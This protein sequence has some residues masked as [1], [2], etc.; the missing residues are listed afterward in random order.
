MSTGKL[1]MQALAEPSDMTCW[2]CSAS[3]THAYMLMHA[4]A[5]K[6][7]ITVRVMIT[8][9]LTRA[10]NISFLLWEIYVWLGKAMFGLRRAGVRNPKHPFPGSGKLCWGCGGL[11]GWGSEPQAYLSRL[12][13]SMLR[14]RRAGVSNPKHSFPGLGKLC[15]RFEVDGA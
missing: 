7:C 14:A 13:K 11:E 3:Q 2:T 15:L 4:Q 9:L 5:T 1:A 10:P 6:Y 8:R 12:G